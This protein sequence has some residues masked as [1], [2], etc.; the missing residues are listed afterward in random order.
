MVDATQALN[1]AVSYSKDL[2]AIQM[3]NIEAIQKAQQAMLEGI[4]ILAKNQAEMLEGTLRRTFDTTPPPA[5]TSPADVRAAIAGQI[6]SLKTTIEESQ[7]N[8][9]I[10]SELA[11]RSGGEVANILQ[12]RFMAALDEFKAALEPTPQS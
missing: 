5:P 2:L 7:A 9:N 8:S 11:A 1:G 12:T 4:R 10:L 3:R 6:D